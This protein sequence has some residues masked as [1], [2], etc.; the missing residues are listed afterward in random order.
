MVF[1]LGKIIYLVQKTAVAR[2]NCAHGW[3]FQDGGGSYPSTSPQYNKF[4]LW[5]VE[6]IPLGADS[7]T[8][9]LKTK[10]KRATR[11]LF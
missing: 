10:M 4:K 11:R 2:N 6:I 1:V 7:A 8:P 9:C 5:R 3:C